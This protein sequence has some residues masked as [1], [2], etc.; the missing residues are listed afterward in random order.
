MTATTISSAHSRTLTRNTQRQ[1]ARRPAPRTPARPPAPAPAGRPQA[2]S[3]GI[4]RSRK[5][6]LMMARLPAGRWP[7]PGPHDARADEHT[8]S[9]PAQRGARPNSA[10]P[11]EHRLAPAPVRQHP[12]ATR[13]LASTRGVDDPLQRGG[14]RMQLAAIVSRATLTTSGHDGEELAAGDDEERHRA[15]PP[16]PGTSAQGHAGNTGDHALQPAEDRYEQ[17]P[18]RRCGAPASTSRRSRSGCGRTSAT[19]AP[20]RAARD[21]APRLRPRRHHFDLASSTAPY[22]AAERL[23]PH[24]RGLPPPRELIISTKA[25]WDMWPGP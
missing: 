10:T 3:G 18:Y 11:S 5:I 21:P 17:I 20:G 7:E 13:R 9:A 25:G 12:P 24:G 2:D 22:G 19:T 16:N 8:R 15:V 14:A 23:R 4:A 1:P 6:A